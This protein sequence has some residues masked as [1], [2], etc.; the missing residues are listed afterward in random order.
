MATE[1][2]T[3][4]DQ[5]KS[6][7]HTELDETYHSRHGAVQESEHIFIKHGLLASPLKNLKI[8]EFGFGTGLNCLLTL[9]HGNDKTIQYTSI[10]KYPISVDTALELDYTNQLAIENN[11]V[12][13][14]HEA[15]WNKTHII[16]N[17]FTI[18][19]IQ[20]DFRSALLETMEYD[21]VY[22]D[23]FSPNSQPELWS[24]E[25]FSKVFRS[26]K[27]NSSLTT[28][29][30]KGEIRRRLEKTGFTVEKLPGPPGKR[31]FIRARKL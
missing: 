29:C 31:E 30:C 5:S 27:L 18:H 15:T 9:I 8:L 7:Y 21:L 14:I 6:L 12:Q 19:K 16:R 10:E 25:I 13:V 17:N 28:Y 3:T 22:F 23:A 2:I 26:M 24:E 11:L 1:I 4:K 20:S